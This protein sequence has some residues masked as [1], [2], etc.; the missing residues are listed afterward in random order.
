MQW[1]AEPMNSPFESL[2]LTDLNSQEQKIIL[3]YLLNF[4]ENT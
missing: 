4:A 2:S 3:I 1:S